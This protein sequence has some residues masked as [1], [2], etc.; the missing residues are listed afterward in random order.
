MYTCGKGSHGE[1]GTGRLDP[2]VTAARVEHLWD[3]HRIRSVAAGLMH[4]WFLNEDGNVLGSGKL[5]D[6]STS[7]LHGLHGISRG[8]YA[9]G[10]Y[11]GDVHEDES[12]VLDEHGLQ[13]FGG[14]TLANHNHRGMA[15]DAYG[16]YLR[17][18]ALPKSNHNSVGHHP[19]TGQ[20]GHPGSTLQHFVPFIDHRSRSIEVQTSKLLYSESLRSLAEVNSAQ[21]LWDDMAEMSSFSD[22]VSLPT[23]VGGGAGLLGSIVGG[24]GTNT[25]ML[26][27]E[28]MRSMASCPGTGR[29]IGITVSGL[30]VVVEPLKS[31]RAFPMHRSDLPASWAQSSLPCSVVLTAIA[32]NGGA[33]KGA[34]GEDFY[35]V[36]TNN[37]RVVV[38]WD[39]EDGDGERPSGSRN[40]SSKS[41]KVTM[42][43]KANRTF[44]TQ[45]K[46]TVTTLRVGGSDETVE[47]TKKEPKRENMHGATGGWTGES[48]EES[49]GL[50][51]DIAAS[52]H[53]IFVSDGRTVW[54]LPIPSK[55]KIDAI[56]SLGMHTV[57][58]NVLM[59]VGSGCAISK[60]EANSRGTLGAVTDSG[61]L[62]LLGDVVSEKD[63]SY[64]IG[65]TDEK[66]GRIWEGLR[67]AGGGREAVV[68]SG[69]H[70]VTDV[71]VGE[72]HAL[73][74]VV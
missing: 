10:S 31:V 44:Y 48:E 53:D 1:L 47:N 62:W 19:Q 2:V 65:K 6:V 7:R 67:S 43:K 37:G 5:V 72:H 71:S 25:N 23:L 56:A 70:G 38:W 17:G 30:P 34:V 21:K 51:R 29:S 8:D 9:Y 60:I 52:L 39:S 64:I 57:K 73:A 35:A 15:M 49:N 24:N 50:F 42:T 3:H 61:H 13:F 74:V 36:L 68:V 27:S 46:T 20:G 45:E 18:D 12:D 59:D 41:L 16:N 4:T 33:A 54:K 11:F 32:D 55:N 26:N 58:D 40:H 28:S 22:A 63:M 66:R 69:L 14:N